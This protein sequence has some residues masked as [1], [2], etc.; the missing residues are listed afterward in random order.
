MSLETL[1]RI[2]LSK[3]EELFREAQIKPA[4]YDPKRCIMAVYEELNRDI[5][6]KFDDHYRRGVFDG[7]DN[8]NTFADHKIK[9]PLKDPL[10]YKLGKADG[11]AAWKIMEA[12][13]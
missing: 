5:Y 9:D 11:A 3:V 2:D 1:K 6:S 12:A 7:W 13:C 10:K 8:K 4:R